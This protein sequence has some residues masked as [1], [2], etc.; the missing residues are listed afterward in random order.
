MTYGRVFRIRIDGYSQ[1]YHIKKNVFRSTPSIY[2][3][4]SLSLHPTIFGGNPRFER[5]PVKN[6]KSNELVIAELP[7]DSIGRVHGLKGLGVVRKPQNIKK[8]KKVL[9]GEKHGNK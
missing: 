1:H 8:I 4:D 6:V 7:R 5:G 3:E 2:K 9:H